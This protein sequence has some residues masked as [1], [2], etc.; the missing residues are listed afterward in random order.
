MRGRI[1]RGGQVG[2]DARRRDLE[3]PVRGRNAAR[4]KG[5]PTLRIRF[6]IPALDR[7]AQHNRPGQRVGDLGGGQA[8]GQRAAV[9]RRARDRDTV[10]SGLAL[11]RPE[12]D[13]GPRGV[14]EDEGERG[15]PVGELGDGPRH[16]VLLGHIDT[17]PGEI[18]VRRE[19]DLLYGRGSVDAK[20]PMAAFVM[21]AAR[22]ATAA[23]YASQT[24][25]GGLRVTV[26]EYQAILILSAVNGDPRLCERVK[27]GYLSPRIGWQFTLKRADYDRWVERA[28]RLVRQ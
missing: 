1:Q 22:Y 27:V 15:N 10:D 11:A 3:R 18:A 13:T 6:E 25:E 5:S 4:V 17:V 14:G 12:G 26:H 9:H 20:G 2:V 8:G 19:G 23:R 16:I 28:R 7:L 21:A 24:S